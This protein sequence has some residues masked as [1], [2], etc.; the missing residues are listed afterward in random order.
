MKRK[1]DKVTKRRKKQR[2]DT[3]SIDE[4]FV[5][6]II[7]S[8]DEKGV[9]PWREE[10]KAFVPYPRN[11]DTGR[12]YTG[13]NQFHLSMQGGKYFGTFKQ[14]KHYNTTVK[15]GESG[16]SILYYQEISKEDDEYFHVAK[17]HTVFG[18]SQTKGSKELGNIYYPHYFQQKTT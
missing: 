15:Q 3:E 4:K 13:F 10:H 11:I 9:L 17:H 6:K 16:I 12:Y 5:K 7:E 14:M 8:I 1:N 18:V 2:D